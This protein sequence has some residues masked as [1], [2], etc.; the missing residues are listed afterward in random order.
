LIPFVENLREFPGTVVVKQKNYLGRLGNEV[1]LR[2]VFRSIKTKK[3][4]EE[5]KNLL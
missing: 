3:E 5:G 2:Y 1:A 4:E